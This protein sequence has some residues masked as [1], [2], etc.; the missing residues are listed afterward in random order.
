MEHMLRLFSDEETCDISFKVK[1]T[2]APESSSIALKQICNAHKVV[3]KTCATGSILP[4]NDV[5]PRIFHTVV[6][7]MR[8]E[9]NNC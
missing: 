7:H 9:Y 3:L 8:R 5:H 4:V 6:V 1:V 2:D